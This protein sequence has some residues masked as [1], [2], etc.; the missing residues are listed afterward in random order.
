M[1]PKRMKLLN[2]CVCA[3]LLCGC[4]G[5]DEPGKTVMADSPD[6]DE[7]PVDTFVV[8][9]HASIAGVSTPEG[10]SLRKANDTAM[11]NIRLAISGNPSGEENM[12]LEN[13][14]VKNPD[15]GPS[16]PGGSTMMDK[17]ITE[18]LV[19]PMVAFQNDVKG[20]VEMRFVVETDGRLSGIIVQKGIGY[21]C[22]EAAIDLIKEMPKWI[23]GKKGGVNV[24]C[25][26]V[27]PL[28]FD[29]PDPD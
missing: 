6:A 7:S 19:Y 22:D 14:I 28:W 5:D 11:D 26:V 29:K 17:Y 23:P 15:V 16:F 10:E 3:L 13:T 9:G 8:G 4:A 18:H 12:G 1:L 20:T 21:G 2:L 27:L 25:V 24:R